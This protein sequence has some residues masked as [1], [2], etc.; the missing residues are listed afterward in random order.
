MTPTQR[1]AAAI[2]AV[3]VCLAAAT[4]S[5]SGSLDRS[6]IAECPTTTS[7]TDE[8]LYRFAGSD[9]GEIRRVP[10]LNSGT[11]AKARP[12]TT[13][14]NAAACEYFSQRFASAIAE[15]WSDDGTRTYDVAYYK[16][17]SY[18]VTVFDLRPS[19]DPDTYVIGRDGIA[20]WDENFEQVA[21]L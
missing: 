19:S 10:G 4:V 9:N 17:R 16:W 14:R 11:V 7:G 1:P 3:A 5:L 15:T 2:C 12:L 18:Y 6:P 21:G 13:A 8:V 20:V